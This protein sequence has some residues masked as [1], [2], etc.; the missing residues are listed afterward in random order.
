MPVSGRAAVHVETSEPAE[1][2]LCMGS[3]VGDADREGDADG[4]LV[5]VVDGLELGIFEG[6][7]V[8]CREGVN[9]GTMLILGETEGLV[10]LVGMALMEGLAEG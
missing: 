9:D 4:R 8:G 2:S 10:L 3:M 6:D 5:G 7:E 1:L